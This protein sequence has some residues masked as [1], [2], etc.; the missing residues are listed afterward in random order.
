MG[1]KL[2]LAAAAVAVLAMIV[3]ASLAP[4]AGSIT[5]GRT[6][7][8]LLK[9]RQVST[10][11]LAPRGVSQGDLRVTHA[12]LYNPRETKRIGTF[13]AVC[14]VT[15]PARTEDQSQIT[16]CDYT[17]KL[18]RG[19]ISLQ[20]I[21]SRPALGEVTPSDVAAVTGGTGPYQNARGELH[22]PRPRG[23]QQKRL[24]TL[25]LIP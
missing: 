2:A 17:I 7:R 19:E 5:T 24:L 10:V 16:Q 18:A 13:D 11:D 9:N 3:A 20:T 15:K 25:H 14:F 23:P 1:R 8:V 22:L 12:P 21:N 4:P 6:I